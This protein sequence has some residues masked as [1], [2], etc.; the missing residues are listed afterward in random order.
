MSSDIA[1]GIKELN[2][3]FAIFHKPEHRL[4]Q[5]FWRNRRKFY[6][7]FWALRDINLEIKR[8]ETVGILGR[9]GAGK[10]TLLQ[11][12]SGTLQPTS[13]ELTVNGRVAALL[14]LGAGF[15]PEFSGI[16]NARLASSILGLADELIEERLEQILQFAGLGDFIHQ[17]VKVY[18]SGMYA[19][20]AFAVAA[21]VDADILII[22]EILAVGDA[23]F[24]QKCMRFINDFKSRGTLLFVSHDTGS[25]VSLCDRAVWLDSGGLREVGPTKEVC[26]NYIA[27]INNENDGEESFRIGGTRKPTPATKI[28]DSRHELLRS[29]Q[30]R[31]EIEVFSFDPDAP[32]FGHQGAKISGV[33]L[34]APSGED[35]PV[36]EGGE[37]VIL[38]ISAKADLA[39]ERPIIGFYVKD[40][41]GQY[42]F[43]DNTYLTYQLSPYPIPAGSHFAGRFRFQLPYLP[44]GDY[45]VLASIAE[46][47]QKDHIQHHWVD[48]ALIFR[49]HT[50]HTQRGLIGVPML[51]ISLGP[52]DNLNTLTECQT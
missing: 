22:D 9:N 27:A 18:S 17:P 34:L 5:M 48:E 24:S 21:H 38:E 41:L 50:S 42:L 28:L 37:E 15:N 14:E 26:H 7:E 1:I 11:I 29:S 32:W 44:T 2:K 51:D 49:V 52:K 47:T 8:G 3:V 23:A 16:E 30:H 36:L 4:Y 6:D 43:G 20:L 33:R 39:I 45:A 13:G 12:I 31:N 10:S 25:V 35:Q 46:G 40:K 19:R